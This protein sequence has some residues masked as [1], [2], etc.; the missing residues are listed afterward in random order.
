LLVIRP[1]GGGFQ[2]AALLAFVSTCGVALRDV[3]T[4]KL[5]S[6][7][8][9]LLVAASTIVVMT[10]AGGAIS[11]VSPWSP[12]E[13]Q[14]LVYLAGAAVTVLLGNIA[15][16]IAFRD[17]DVSAVSPFRYTLIVWA[18]IAGFM[19]FGDVPGPT[20]WAGIGLIVGSGIYTLYRESVTA[21][22]SA[23][24]PPDA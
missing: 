20:Q 1:G 22:Q 18:M 21:R 4:R 17:V 13:L 15:I 2:A 14:A 9:N 8:P 24:A 7:V 11:V 12:V 3:I 6:D 23:G 5:P 10:L 16:I 19:V